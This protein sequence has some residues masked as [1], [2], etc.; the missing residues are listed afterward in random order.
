[1]LV[2][3]ATRWHTPAE[4]PVG[5]HSFAP[6]DERRAEVAPPRPWLAE[7][8]V[9]PTGAAQPEL[10]SKRQRSRA[11][12]LVPHPRY[13][14]ASVP[15]GEG[16]S[17]AAVRASYWGYR[18]AE[19]FPE[20]A[21]VADW[22]HQNFTTFPRAIYVDLL[23]HCRDC[24]RPFLFF[25]REQKHWYEDL[26]FYV[27]ARCVRCPACRK[28]EGTLRRRFARYAEA[29]AKP[30]LDDEALRIALGD[31]LFVW[32]AGLLRDESKLRRWKNL[33][34][35]KLPSAKITARLVAVVNALD[36]EKKKDGSAT[37]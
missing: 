35:R 12:G 18:D 14:A 32:E 8:L 17:E 24:R 31:A 5:V 13:G 29:V 30:S 7:R 11:T 34:K 22:K 19:L 15:S 23:E 26:G 25:A 36:A 2:G 1:M 20:S 16:L 27:D 21:I 4:S 3:C 6:D 37:P 33:A 9:R 10:M 28:T